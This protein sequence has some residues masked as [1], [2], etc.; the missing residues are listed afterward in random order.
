VAL[1][2]VIANLVIL[3]LTFTVFQYL[4]TLNSEIEAITVRSNRVSLLTDE[5]RISA[6]SILKNQRKILTGNADE[7]T[8]EN[9]ETLTESF[10]LVLRRLATSQI[11]F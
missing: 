5:I 2:F 10:T 11:K 1:S 8:V 7:Q 6:V 9:L 4:S 3:V